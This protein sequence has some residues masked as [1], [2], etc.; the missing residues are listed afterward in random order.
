MIVAVVKQFKKLEI[1]QKT[2]GT[3]TG[4]ET[5]ASASALQCSTNR[6]MKTYTLG[7]GQFV[8]FILSR[9]VNCIFAL[10]IMSIP[11]FIPF[12]G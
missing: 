9:G 11:C 2:F 10:H 1:N 12:T 8:E 6:A 5:M 3:S 4:F 7:V